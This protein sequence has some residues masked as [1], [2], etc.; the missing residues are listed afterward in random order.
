MASRMSI[1]KVFGLLKRDRK[2]P[3]SLEEMHQSVEASAA[4]GLERDPLV[5]MQII[6]RLTP[7]FT[8]PA[9]AWTWYR[10]EV[11]PGFG[12]LTAKQLVEAGRGSEVLEYIDALDAGIHS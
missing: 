3:V 1:A 4:E 2:R 7:R 12:G 11:L 9:L 6:G 8:A 5:E 10:A